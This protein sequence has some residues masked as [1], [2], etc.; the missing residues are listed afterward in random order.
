[1]EDAFE[2]GCL[3]FE[4]LCRGRLGGA[5]TL[6]RRLFE[7]SLEMQAWV[8][9]YPELE[10]RFIK[11]GGERTPSST[12]LIRLLHGTTDAANQRRTY[13]TL[14]SASHGGVQSQ[15][16]LLDDDSAS[17]FKVKP[18]PA[19]IYRSHR[20]LFGTLLS[21]IDAA[22]GGAMGMATRYD[23]SIAMNH[24]GYLSI[25]RDYETSAPELGL[26]RAEEV[27]WPPSETGET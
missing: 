10:R 19:Y 8:R 18:A 5:A 3:A 14:C 12:E 17:G 22:I 20:W 2:T 9:F 11:D 16:Y 25:I 1:M 6:T 24:H 26:Y 27:D 7:L 15:D 21:T 13:S 23:P 4:F